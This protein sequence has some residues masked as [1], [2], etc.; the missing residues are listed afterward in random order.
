MGGDSLALPQMSAVAVTEFSSP[1][2]I[3]VSEEEV[4]RRVQIAREAATAEADGRMRIECEHANKIARDRVT[5]VLK[6]FEGERADYFRHVEAEV[7]QLALAIARKIL[8]REAELDPTLLAAL[9][10]IAL[11]QMQCKSVVRV[12]VS[13][14]NADLWRRCGDAS[15]GSRWEI[16]SDEALTTGDC[17]V[18]TELGTADFGFEAQLRGVEESFAQLLSHRPDAQSHH[19]ARA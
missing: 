13:A 18:E 17:I 5:E 11:D 9:V 6:R 10:R 12:R 7:V 3:G 16:T 8:H 4:A 2:V 15:T 14:E 1:T 19:V